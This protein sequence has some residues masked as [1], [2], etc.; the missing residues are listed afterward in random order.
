M[1][2]VANN[3]VKAIR[4]ANPEFSDLQQKK[5][6][7][8]LVCLFSEITKIIAYYIIFYILGIHI[9]F[10]VSLIFLSSLRAVTGGYHADTYWGCFTFSLIMF[11]SIIFAGKYIVLT[12]IMVI[13]IMAI[14]MVLIGKFSPVDNKNKR[15]KSM[16]RKKNLKKIALIIFI[17]LN[18]III[19]IP[20]KYKTTAELSI[21][22]AVLLMVIGKLPHFNKS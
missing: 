13:I 20:M 19:F 22:V 5:M 10:L 14:S 12:N 4:N 15:I 8:G 7:Y 1:E 21:F 3:I 16:D 17:V 11:F 18:I 9:Y 6:E 2:K